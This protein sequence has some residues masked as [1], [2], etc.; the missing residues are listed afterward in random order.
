MFA[1]A[2]ETSLDGAFA[3]ARGVKGYRD[4]ER[5]LTELQLTSL[6]E[7]V[8]SGAYASPL[9]FARAYAQLGRTEDMFEYLKRAFDDK[10]PGLVFLNVERTWDRVRGE[11]RFVEYLRRLAIN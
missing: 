9:D 3:A 4:L 1:A 2:G 6:E 7:R 10:A 5:L 11:P 8:S